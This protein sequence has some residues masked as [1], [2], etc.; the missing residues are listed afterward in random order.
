MATR[1]SSPQDL[2]ALKEKALSALALRSAVAPKVQVTVHVGTCGIAAGAREVVMALAEELTAAGLH[3]V[4]LQQADC[5]GTCGQEPMVTVIDRAGKEFRYGHL[6]GGM[7]R[8]V[9]REHIV[10]GKPVADALIS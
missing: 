2:R 4:K 1:I 10:G 8:R 5:A 9:V 6:D 7:A 3:D